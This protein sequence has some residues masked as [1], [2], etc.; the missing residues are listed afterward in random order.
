MKFSLLTLLPIVFI[1]ILLVAIQHLF[2]SSSYDQIQQLPFKEYGDLEKPTI[3]IVPGLDGITAFYHDIVPELTAKYHVVVYH[4]PLFQKLNS[5][6]Y[7]FEFLAKDLRDILVELKITKATI[8]GESFGGVI[9]QYF[10]YL[11]PSYV[12][13]LVL[14]SSMAKLDLPPDVAWKAKYLLPSLAY[15]GGFHPTLAQV[16]LPLSSFLFMLPLCLSFL[17]HLRSCSC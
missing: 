3:V 1:S 8:I 2:L 10:A 15:F 14:L 12:D 5:Y 16:S 7:S 13:R 17:D 6:E 4:L 9:T 11:Y